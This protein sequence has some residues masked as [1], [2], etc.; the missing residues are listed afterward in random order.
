MLLAQLLALS[1]VMAALVRRT[2][3]HRSAPAL[4]LFALYLLTPPVWSLGVILWKDV[5]MAAA[6]TLAGVA[7]CS[8]QFAR[9]LALLVVAVLFRHNAIFA[10]APLVL[11][12]VRRML[13]GR[14]RWRWPATA[15]AMA[16]LALAPLAA[17]SF[18]APRTRGRS[19]RCWY[20][21]R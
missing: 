16:A 7:L 13:H 14:E 21:T 3:V 1:I 8:E 9:S 19:A 6:M 4:A 20:S 10:A 12:V 11:P 2:A 17:E 15:G 18:S 5:L